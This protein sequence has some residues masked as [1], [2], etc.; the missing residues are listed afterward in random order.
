MGTEQVPDRE[1]MI[2]LCRTAFTEDDKERIRS[3]AGAVNDWEK[4]TWL[5]N[6]HGISALAWVNLK[7]MGLEQDIPEEYRTILY[8]SYLKSLSR[9]TN[10]WKKYCEM[11]DLLLEKGIKPVLIKG[12][13]LEKSVYGN[14]GLR[15]MNDVDFLVE[16][17]RCQEAWDYLLTRGYT[18]N[19][20]KSP[21]YRKILPFIGK[22]MPELYK[23]GISFEM[24]VTLFGNA[25][26]REPDTGKIGMGS[27]NP[28]EMSQ[29]GRIVHFLYLVKHL[30][31]HETV[32]GESQLRLY[33]DLVVMLKEY[34]DE[35]QK[36]ALFEEAEQIGILDILMEKLFIIN[37]FWGD[38]LSW[39]VKNM[40]K[41]EG[42]ENIIERFREF[43]ENPKN[44]T[45]SISKGEIYRDNIK[46]IK[47]LRRRVIFVTG[48]IFPS[49]EFM[50]QRY[51]K[52]IAMAV[53]PMI[54]RRMGKMLWLAGRWRER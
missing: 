8:N 53:Q 6:E 29:F 36:A 40:I 15:Q 19:M 24:H 28:E 31:Y 5:V 2:K 3:L 13:A 21:L 11:R 34:R 18:H 46:S 51:N 41:G 30:H 35:I 16:K 9:N 52:K 49:V 23:E 10:L 47:G 37:T 48:D 50:K 14:K 54:F 39:T 45:P 25:N 27:T 26:Y 1:L 32:K 12:M 44:N 42:A 22:H 38:E 4:F 7:N 43:I 20:I 17:E 33:T